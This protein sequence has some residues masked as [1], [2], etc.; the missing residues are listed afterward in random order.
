MVTKDHLKSVLAGK[1]RFL[2]IKDVRCCNP[3]I[4]DEVSVT[5]LYQK[6]IKQSGMADLFPDK[7]PKGRT[8]CRAYMF[9]CWNTLHPDQVQ[10]VIQHASS[11]RYAID[12]QKNTDD[13][14]VLS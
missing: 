8:C 10:Q 3:P 14:I 11:Q 9:N 1:K 5:N 7:F 4:F 12:S 2:K 6:V 13:A